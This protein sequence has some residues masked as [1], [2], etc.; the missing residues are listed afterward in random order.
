PLVVTVAHSLLVGFSEG[1]VRTTDVQQTMFHRACVMD[2]FHGSGLTLVGDAF[3]A[4]T[5]HPDA[6]AQNRTVGQ[7]VNVA[8]HNRSVGPNFFALAYALF[9]GQADLALW[10]LGGHGRPGQAKA[11]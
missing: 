3:E 4:A 11:R 1:L 6:V 5:E 8:F 10:N 2:H 9:E 7:V